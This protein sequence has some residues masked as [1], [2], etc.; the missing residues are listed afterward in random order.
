MKIVSVLKRCILDSFI[1]TIAAGGLIATVMLA[2]NVA[3]DDCPDEMYWCSYPGQPN[4]GTCCNNGQ[5]CCY[6]S[7]NQTVWCSTNGC[8]N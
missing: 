5:S 1:L 7:G 4:N 8:G 6:D 3:A 2:S